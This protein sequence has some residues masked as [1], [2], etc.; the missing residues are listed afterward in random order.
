MKEN[1]KK[2]LGYYLNA[3]IQH[4]PSASAMLLSMLAV[5]ILELVKP[6]YYKQFF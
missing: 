6:L 1:T 2:T 4:K 5:S 3:S